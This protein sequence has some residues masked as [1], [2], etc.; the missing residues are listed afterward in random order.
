M[1]FDY[2][3]NCITHTYDIL[4]LALD[5]LLVVSMKPKQTR[6]TYIS[7]HLAVS[8]IYN[9]YIS[10]EICKHAKIT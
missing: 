5:I 8:I 3:I 4:T 10:Y 9:Y 6:E 2:Y 1:Q 7:K